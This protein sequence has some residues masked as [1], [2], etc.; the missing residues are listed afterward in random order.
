M[1]DDPTPRVSA[2]APDTPATAKTAPTSTGTQTSPPSRVTDPAFAAFLRAR[3]DEEARAAD[4]RHVDD[5][6]AARRAQAGLA[7]LDDLIA[8]I[9]AGR[10]LDATSLHLLKIGYGTHPDFRREWHATH[11]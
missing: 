1:N 4:E 6:A 3:R 8:G 7:V 9:A 11:G 5:P 10:D 2:D